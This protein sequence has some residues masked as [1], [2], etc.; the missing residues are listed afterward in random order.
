MELTGQ[1]DVLEAVR[2]ACVA[3]WDEGAGAD[4]ED[5]RAIIARLER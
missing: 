4:L 2:A 5:A 3:V 1:G